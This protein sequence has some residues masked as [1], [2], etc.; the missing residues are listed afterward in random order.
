MH[1]EGIDQKN[2]RLKWG[3]GFGPNVKVDPRYSV[4]H[5]R[6]LTHYGSGQ[7]NNGGDESNLEE[8]P[9]SHAFRTKSY[10]M[11]SQNWIAKP[12]AL[13]V[14]K[15][16]IRTH[17]FKVIYI[18]TSDFSLLNLVG[19]HLQALCA[20]NRQNY[21]FK[22]L[23]TKENCREKYASRRI[24]YTLYLPIRIHQWYRITYCFAQF[25]ARFPREFMYSARFIAKAPISPLLS[26]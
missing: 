2:A 4:S 26:Q 7:R 24:A 23:G 10:Q 11:D 3:K 13:F 18:Q 21:E 22:R 12:F 15:P 8:L 1:I 19:I 17:L 16:I 6:E 14:A 9:I 20:R 25:V 5:C